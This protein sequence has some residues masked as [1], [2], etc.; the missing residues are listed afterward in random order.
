MTTMPDS[1]DPNDSGTGLRQHLEVVRRR[2][3]IVLLVTSLAVAAAALSFLQ[4]PLY[5]ASTTIVVG[6]GNSL[7]QPGEANAVTPFT[8]TMGDLVRSKIVMATVIDD[9]D[10]QAETPESLLESLSVSINPETAV[11]RV[12]VDDHDPERAVAIAGEIGSVFSELVDER[13]GNAAPTTPSQPAQLPLT[14]TIFDPARAEPDPVAPKPVKN[15]AAALLIGLVLGLLG[16]FMREHFDRRLRTRE[17]VE[18]SFGVPVIG[19]IPFVRG[20]KGARPNV[21][22]ADNREAAEAFRALRANL[23]YLAVQ[24]PL[25]TLLVTSAAPE[26]G[27]TTVTAH[28]AVAIG[29]SGATT[30]AVDAD[31][32]RPQLVEALGAQNDGPGLTGALVGA[33]ALEDAL[34]DLDLPGGEG[35]A[36]GQVSFLPSGP[37]PPNPSELVS[38]VQMNQL[39]GRLTELYDYV[40][41]DSPP[42]LLVADALE[43][44]RHVDGVV[45]V[46]RANRASRDDA[47]EVRALTQRLGIHLLGVV[48][49]DVEPL[50]S[51][52][53]A[54]G[55]AP[56]ATAAPVRRRARARRDRVKR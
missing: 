50:G 8:A 6:Q 2:K 48:L 19:Q 56:V 21:R 5:R 38:S 44:A 45:L 53:G 22:D 3:W 47:R 36:E 28:L 49:T 51:Y 10:L 55:A 7:F 41:I 46:V 9:L 11:I 35:S 17:A 26:Q 1:L 42:M 30:V 29:R 52:Y 16:A 23:Q 24:S 43:I 13:F 39:L 27:K 25:R 33:G 31:L 40:L 20:K 37:L 18:Q 14:A 54:Y 15:I 4:D 32:R 12:S 34:R